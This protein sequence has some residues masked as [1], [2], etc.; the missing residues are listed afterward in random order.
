MKNMKLRAWA[1]QN[2]RFKKI[3]NFKKVKN[4]N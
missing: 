2:Q 1:V 3:K 4:K